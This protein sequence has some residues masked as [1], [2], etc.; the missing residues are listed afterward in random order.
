MEKLVE[1]TVF[2]RGT[3]VVDENLPRRHFVHQKSHLPHSGSNLGRRGGKPATNRF[4]YGAALKYTCTKD[5][6]MY[7]LK[8]IQVFICCS[9]VCWLISST[10]D[11]VWFDR[12]GGTCS[13]DLKAR[14]F[15]KLEAI[16]FSERRYISTKLHDTI[17]HKTVILV[18]TIGRTLN[19]I[20]RFMDAQLWHRTS[21][22]V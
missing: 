5:W 16:R 11:S 20:R 9:G 14:S 12:F 6:F 22:V 3:E 7:N 1:G 17:S 2:G 21:S 4:T 15:L 19:V 13:I 18:V 8:Y 10:I